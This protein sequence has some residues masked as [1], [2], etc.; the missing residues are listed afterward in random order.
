MGHR[1]CGGHC[2]TEN[3]NAATTK[4]C[5]MCTKP[6]HLPC[7]DVI[8]PPNK[9]F[10]IDNIVFICDACLVEID[11]PISPDR[12]R[13]VP[14]NNLLKQSILA[15]NTNGN[16]TLTQQQQQQPNTGNTSKKSNKRTNLCI[17]DIDFV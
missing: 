6:S 5:R 17:V 12:K 15:A 10:I 13:K 1:N 9:L 16:V 8:M 11:N 3:I 7:Y 4:K 2:P 14:S